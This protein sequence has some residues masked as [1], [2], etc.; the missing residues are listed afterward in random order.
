MEGRSISVDRRRTVS[1]IALILISGCV[2]LAVSADRA[3]ALTGQGIKL[4]DAHPKVKQTYSPIPATDPTAGNVADPTVA[5]CQTLAGETLLQVD[6]SFKRQFGTL[7]TF[8]T[9]WTGAGNDIDAYF[10]D[11]NGK[12]IAKA[13][14]ISTSNPEIIRLG[15]LANGTYYMCVVSSTGQ[16]TGFT[17]DASM[18]FLSLYKYTPPPKTPFPKVGG[19]V[20]PT[21]VA[22]PAPIATP[23]AP[24][25]T[26][27]PVVTPG[28]NGPN[29]NQG[30]VGVAGAEQ[31]SSKTKRS[32]AELVFLIL[33]VV[34]AVV[35]IGFVAMRIRRDT[36]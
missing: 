16:N 35:G 13:T 26:A 5:N 1:L 33:T 29:A 25:V 32:I 6:V 34:I 24:A 31:A 15:N 28:P 12:E 23:A 22:T 4:D 7:A 8:A 18:E 30:L 27:E 21:P 3:G 11:E 19:N 17:V 36:T 2:L 14:D 10:Y 9:S 20:A